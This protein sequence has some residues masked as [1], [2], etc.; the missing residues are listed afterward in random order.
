MRFP[1]STSV[2]KQ[3]VK[4]FFYYLFLIICSDG[5]LD[6][7]YHVCKLYMVDTDCVSTELDGTTLK[8]VISF[9]VLADWCIIGLVGAGYTSLYCMCVLC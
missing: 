7:L 5:P 2:I 9:N 1:L 8:P 4:V 3:V 6:R